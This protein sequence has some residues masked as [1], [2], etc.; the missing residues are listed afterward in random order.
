LYAVFAHTIILFL[1]AS[2]ISAEINSTQ[3]QANESL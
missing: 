2:S 1:F 3:T